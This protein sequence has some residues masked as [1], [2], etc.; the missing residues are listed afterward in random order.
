M[1]Y[2]IISLMKEDKSDTSDIIHHTGNEPHLLR[3]IVRTHQVLMSGFS[4]AVGVPGARFALMRILANAFPNDMGVMEIARQLGI[5]AASVTRSVK[6]MEKENLILRRPDARDGR[7]NHVK[8]SA[9]GLK[10]FEHI[11]QRGHEL[12][13]SLYSL[14]SPEEMA[15]AADVLGKLRRFIEEKR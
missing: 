7:R 8:L 14:I 9:K 6:E 2:A 4:R 5:N 15:S 1:I 10:V 3:E 11:H 13:C 12:E